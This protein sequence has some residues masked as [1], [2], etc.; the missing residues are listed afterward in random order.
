MTTA[1][2]AETT[3]IESGDANLRNFVDL[4]IQSQDVKESSKI[5][6][7]RTLKQFFRWLRDACLQL[8][9]VSRPTVL[10]YKETLL[11]RGLS[12]LTVSSYITSVRRFFEFAE[13]NKVFPNVAKGIKSPKRKQQFRKMP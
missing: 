3:A 7:R 1:I 4:F 6:Y 11:K 8:R 13:A 12:S 5:L 9:D 10:E 2:T